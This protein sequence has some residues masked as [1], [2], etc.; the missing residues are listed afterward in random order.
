MSK[1]DTPTQ[2]NAGSSLLKSYANRSFVVQLNNKNEV[3]I[4]EWYPFPCIVVCKLPNCVRKKQRD[5]ISHLNKL[6]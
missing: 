6:K 4:S 1:H 2:R 5:I 3:C